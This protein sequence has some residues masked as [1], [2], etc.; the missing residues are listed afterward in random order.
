MQPLPTHT[1]AMRRRQDVSDAPDAA[2]AFMSLSEAYNVLSDPAARLAYDGHRAPDPGPARRW[3][4]GAGPAT[5]EWEELEQWLRRHRPP[6]AQ[7]AQP[8]RWQ[9]ARA[10]GDERRRADAAGAAGAAGAADKNCDRA[11]GGV[12][13]GEEYP[14]VGE[15]VTYPLHPRV[16]CVKNGY[17][18]RG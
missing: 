2:A 9:Q 7:P 4:P 12:A 5:D 13:G 8:D 6:P 18:S 1:S 16:S 11:G 17:S 15:L 10:T 14:L 3:P